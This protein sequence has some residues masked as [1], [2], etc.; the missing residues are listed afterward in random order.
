MSVRVNESSKQFKLASQIESKTNP[1]EQTVTMSKDVHP[2]SFRALSL[3]EKGQTKKEILTLKL[4]AHAE[5]EISAIK[6]KGFGK[7]DGLL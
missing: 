7:R 6:E 5:K 4:K 1:A 2:S 3:K